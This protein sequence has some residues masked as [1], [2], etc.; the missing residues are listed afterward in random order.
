MVFGEVRVVEHDNPPKDGNIYIRPC[1]CMFCVLSLRDQ[2]KVATR[3]LV[4]RKYKTVKTFGER[5]YDLRGSDLGIY[6]SEVWCCIQGR[7]L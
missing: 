2:N 1:L 5:T 6:W 7:T 4:L 3:T